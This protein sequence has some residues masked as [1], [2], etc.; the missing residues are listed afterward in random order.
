MVNLVA[1]SPYL[2]KQT[3]YQGVDQCGAAFAVTKQFRAFQIGI[4]DPKYESKCPMRSWEMWVGQKAVS[5][6]LNE[7]TLK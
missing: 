4:I 5:R 1:K 7:S 2:P 6:S 3:Y